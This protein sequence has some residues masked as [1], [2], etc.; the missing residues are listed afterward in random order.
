MMSIFTEVFS[1]IFYQICIFS[2]NESPSKTKKC[3]SFYRK[4]SF[5]FRDIQTFVI[6]PFLSTL[7]D[8]TGQMIIYDVMNL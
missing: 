6:F 7:P 1:A 3:F 4:S 2:P 5:R 8:S